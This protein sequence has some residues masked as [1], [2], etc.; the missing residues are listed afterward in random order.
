MALHLPNSRKRNQIFGKKQPHASQEFTRDDSPSSGGCRRSVY[1]LPRMRAQGNGN[2]KR[3]SLM[4]TTNK[5][6]VHVY[7]WCRVCFARDELAHPY[8]HPRTRT[9]TPHPHLQ[10]HPSPSSSLLPPPSPLTPRLHPH[11]LPHPH[12]HPGRNDDAI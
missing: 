10:P 6:C 8:P 3:T 2:L 12:P 1:D 5:V 4:S 7:R 9:L 11:P